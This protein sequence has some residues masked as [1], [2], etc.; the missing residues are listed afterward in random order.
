[1]GL[2]GPMG[3]MGPIGLIHVIQAQPGEGD[4]FDGS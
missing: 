3:L 4:N 1:M 2:I